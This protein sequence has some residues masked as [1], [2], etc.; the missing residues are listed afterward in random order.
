MATLL[1]KDGIFGSY[2]DAC[3]LEQV[4]GM[5]CALRHHRLRLVMYL[6]GVA[7]IPPII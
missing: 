1:V 6:L 7:C 5:H 3:H 2:A 4:V